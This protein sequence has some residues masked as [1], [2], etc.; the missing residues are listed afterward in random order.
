M[1]R[2]Y[3]YGDSG[4][5]YKVRLLLAQLGLDY[6]L[7]E[8][9]IMTGESRTSEFLAKN[10]NGR[11]PLIELDDGRLLAESNAIL[12]Y[13]AEGTVYLPQDRY[14]RA[15]AMQW[16]FF[17]QYSHE[18]NIATTRFWLR[19]GPMSEERKRQLPAKQKLGRDALD[20]ME[21]HLAGRDYFVGEAYSIADIALYAYTHLAGQGG[22]DL[23][24]YP[25][26]RAWLARIASQP[27]HVT[28][29]GA[30]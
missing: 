12:C 26:V 10:P 19:H 13:F 22:F 21:R 1:L 28:M 14:Q 25:A 8:I 23:A 16:L 15:L 11:V 6:A 18:P 29:A 9:D 17:E 3:D 24:A 30:G 4:N 7:T 20:V 2:L 5:G 27:G